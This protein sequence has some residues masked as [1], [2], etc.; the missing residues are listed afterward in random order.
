M[1]EQLVG[2]EHDRRVDYIEFAAGDLPAVKRFYADV[3]GWRFTDYGPEYTSF[4][5]GRLTGGFRQADEP[6]RGGPLVVIFAL[7][8]EAAQAAVNRAGGRIVKPI[9]S[10]PGGRR[11]H[12]VDPAGNELAVWSDRPR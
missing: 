8:L 7:D 6:T 2:T 3:F 4:A 10:F 9:F 12:F 1:T 5:D 11:F